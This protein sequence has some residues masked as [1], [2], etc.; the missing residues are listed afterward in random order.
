MSLPTKW[1]YSGINDSCQMFMLRIAAVVHASLGGGP[2]EQREEEE[3]E[4]DDDDDDDDDIFRKKHASQSRVWQMVARRRENLRANGVE[5]MRSSLPSCEMSSTRY[6]GQKNTVV[7]GQGRGHC[8]DRRAGV[9]HLLGWNM[10]LLWYQRQ[11]AC[12]DL[13]EKVQVSREA[14]LWL[15]RWSQHMLFHDAQN[16]DT[17]AEGRGGQERGRQAG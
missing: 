10:R 9:V 3:E 6:G 14:Q 1:P 2:D 15:L 13:T 17:Q 7:V 16:P 4:E 12:Q 8:S 11:D 5:K